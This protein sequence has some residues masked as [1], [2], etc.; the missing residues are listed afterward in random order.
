MKY[1]MIV[2]FVPVL[3]LLSAYANAFGLSTPPWEDKTLRMNPGETKEITFTLQNMAGDADEKVIIDLENGG[4]VLKITDGKEYYYV[5]LGTKDVAIN[6]VVSIPEDAPIGREWDVKMYLKS[7]IE[8]EEGGMADLTG[9]MIKTFKIKVVPKQTVPKQAIQPA[10][11]KPKEKHG[12][13]FGVVAVILI[14]MVLVLFMIYKKRVSKKK[15]K[16]V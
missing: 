13:L 2:L 3:I 7:I 6:M 4:E 5:P 1:K 9:G 12:V 10:E 15:V 14:A 8:R 16:K 11:L